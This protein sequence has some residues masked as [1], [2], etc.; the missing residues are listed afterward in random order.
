M[1]TSVSEWNGYDNGL[2]EL[3]I[4]AKIRC[5][6]RKIY[7]QNCKCF[8][9]VWNQNWIRYNTVY[10]SMILLNKIVELDGRSYLQLSMSDVRNVHARVFDIC[11]SPCLTS[12]FYSC[13]CLPLANISFSFGQ[14][15]YESEFV[16]KLV[17][18]L[19]NKLYQDHVGSNLKQVDQKSIKS[20]KSRGY[21]NNKTHHLA[22]MTKNTFWN[23]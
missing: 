14:M 15:T 13:L 20:H 3:Q 16:G 5:L 21:C 6:R 4:N 12:S 10:F 18:R 19:A 17:H 7:I 22:W 1:T 8:H 11:P 9:L 23:V 2:F